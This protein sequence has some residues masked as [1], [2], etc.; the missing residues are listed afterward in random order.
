MVNSIN[1]PDAPTIEHSE[2]ESINEPEP[3]VPAEPPAITSLNPA[4]CA[5]SDADFTLFVLGTGF[6]ADSVIHFAGHDEPTTLETDGSVSTG[7]KPSLW[8]NPTTVQVSIKNGAVS[9]NEVDF[10]FMAPAARSSRHGW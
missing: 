1:E 3:D 7:V 10:E 9:S 6:T 2:P 4:S 8:A 5:I